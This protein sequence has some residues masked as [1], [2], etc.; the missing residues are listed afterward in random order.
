MPRQSGLPS[1]ITGTGCE[2][3][4]AQQGVRELKPSCEINREGMRYSGLYHFDEKTGEVTSCPAHTQGIKN[5][6]KAVKVKMTKEGAT[7]S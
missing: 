2:Y 1:A 7:T 3:C 6:A 5:I 4:I